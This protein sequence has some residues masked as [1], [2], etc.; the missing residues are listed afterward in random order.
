MN[1]PPGSPTGTPMERVAH[2][3]S[4]LLHISQIPQKN[5]PNKKKFHPSLKGPRKGASPHVTQNGGPMETD[6]HFQSLT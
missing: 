5:S 2:F 3:Q 6:A 1:P 4:L